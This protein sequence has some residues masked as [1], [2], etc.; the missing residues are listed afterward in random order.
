MR[1][2]GVV[3][4]LFALRCIVPLG[5]TLVVGYAMTRLYARWEAKA[6]VKP[7]VARQHVLRPANSPACWSVR[8]CNPA[9]RAK[10]PAYQHSE[11]TCW[12]ARMM[13][14]GTLPPACPTCRLFRLAPARQ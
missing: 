13:T 14:E 9:S 12:S 3:T 1:E 11:L 7:Q 4:L 2:F 8:D 5:I 6:G 10:C